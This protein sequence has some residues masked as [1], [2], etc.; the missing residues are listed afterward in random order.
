[1]EGQHPSMD[2]PVTA[3]TAAQR[4]RDDGSPWAAITAEASVGVGNDARPILRLVTKSPC[5]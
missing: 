5:G 2:R 3:V 1:M 4:R